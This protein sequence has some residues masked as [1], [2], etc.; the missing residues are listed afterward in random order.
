M[1]V[2]NK[3]IKEALDQ[4]RSWAQ[5]NLRESADTLV[6]EART[7]LEAHKADLERWSK[8]VQ[9][10]K[11]TEEEVKDLVETRIAVDLMEGLKLKGMAVA[12]V[13]K[14]KGAVVDILFSAAF[15]LIPS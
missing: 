7:S 11:L 4:I 9:E 1:E 8:L 15:K 6:N 10:Q 3:I 5:Q 2:V 13:D 12:K 14:F